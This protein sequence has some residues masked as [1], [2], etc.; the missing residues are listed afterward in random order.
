ML[1]ENLLGQ[2]VLFLTNAINVDLSKD[3]IMLN[4][5]N[6]ESQTQA[7]IQ[8]CLINPHTESSFNLLLRTLTNKQH[9]HII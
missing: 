8:G 9:H 2:N 6:P 7:L 4:A 5:L 3:G 1:T